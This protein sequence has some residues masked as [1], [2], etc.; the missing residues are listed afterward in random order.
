ML[1]LT[2]KLQLHIITGQQI[3]TKQTLGTHCTAQALAAYFLFKKRIIQAEQVETHGFWE[4]MT[5]AH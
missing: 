4:E 1:I 3:R 5:G 2:R